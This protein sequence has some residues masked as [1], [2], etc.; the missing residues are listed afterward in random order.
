MIELSWYVARGRASKGAAASL[1]VLRPGQRWALTV[2]LKR[3]HGA[4]NPHG[5]DYELWQWEQGVQATGYVRE[6]PAASL[7]AD[8]GAYALQRWRQQMREAI[9]NRAAALAQAMQRVG[10]DPAQSPRMLGV[11]AALAMGDQQAIARDDWT[12]FRHTGVAHLMSISGLHITLFAWLAALVVGR[13]WRCS[14]RA[15]LWCPAPQAALLAGVLL[16]G[17]YALFSGWGLP[18]QRTVCM[19]ATVAALRVTGLR[20]PWPAVWCLALAVVVVL[21]PWALWQA[22]FW[23]SFVAVGVLLA[24]DARMQGAVRPSLPARAL[25]LWGEQWRIT[26]ALAPLGLMLFGQLSLSGLLANLAAIPWVTFVV[27][28]LA[29]LGALWPPFWT[30]AALA[31]AP[32]L[33]LLQ[34]LDRWGWAVLQL[35][36]PPLWAGLAALG[37]GLA[38]VAPVPAGWRCWGL[39]MCL[40]ALW[41]PPAAPA[42]GEFDLMAVDIGQGNA[43]LLRTA[44]HALLY[45]TGPQYGMD[46]NAGERVL[47]PLLQALRERAP[48]IQ[49]QLTTVLSREAQFLVE[50]RRVDLALLP[51]AFQITRLEAIA[52]FEEDFCLFGAPQHMQGSQGPVAF[53]ELCALPL[54]APDREHDLRQLMERTA[55][56]QNCALNVLYE[57]NQAELSRSLV[58]GGL[59]F[60]VLPRNAFAARDEASVAARDIVEPRLSRIQSLAWSLDQPLTAAGKLVREVVLELVAAMVTDGRL[61]GRLLAAGAL[62]RMGVEA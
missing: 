46:S 31:L 50:T 19:L 30:G 5:F 43:V 3:P 34:W 56:A 2:R 58:Y 14:A 32:L 28:P 26:L 18:A 41:W 37:A 10:M 48:E 1:P 15:C 51:T 21:D 45:D 9:V 52:L 23:L 36:Q 55:L 44:R 16:A 54:V 7:L 13:L 4:R 61:K 12:L 27:T 42:H 35:P 24:T 57:I 47:V 25:A 53:R 29:L 6:Q 33:E 20:W 49:L 38:L 62:P 39:A 40:P 8:T 17:G 60:A 11:V 59:A 22:G